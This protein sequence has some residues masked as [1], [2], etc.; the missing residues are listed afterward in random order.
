MQGETKNFNPTVSETVNCILQKQV[1]CRA[2]FPN[3]SAVPV[4]AARSHRPDL[5]EACSKLAVSWQSLEPLFWSNSIGF[6][7][8][9]L[10]LENLES[11][12]GRCTERQ[13]LRCTKRGPET[14]FLLLGWSFQRPSAL[15]LLTGLSAGGAFRAAEAG[16]EA[17]FLRKGQGMAKR[18][19]VGRLFKL[20]N[21]VTFLENPNQYLW[22]LWKSNGKSTSWAADSNFCLLDGFLLEFSYSLGHLLS[23][24]KPWKM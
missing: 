6:S 13:K 24:G 8:A 1:S 15:V 21:L 7:L 3:R 10:G 18:F 9:C 23:R 14:S 12:A 20:L 22:V 2:V 4:P 5:A 16:S 19:V 17:G 11:R